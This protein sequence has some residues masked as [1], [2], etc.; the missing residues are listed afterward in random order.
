MKASLLL[1]NPLVLWAAV[2]LGA[3]GLL[4][5]GLRAGLE[6]AFL[7]FPS[8]RLSMTPGDVGLPF[9]EVRL[10]AED[11]VELHG[12]FV[13]GPG[14]ATLIWFHGNAGNIG[15]R[16]EPLKL[17]REGLG[18]SIFLFDY[19]GYGRS[20]GS[21]S[22]AGLYRDA[23]AALEYVRGRPDV[24]GQ[25]IVY[26]GQSLGAAVAAHLAT[27]HP[28][29]GLILE[30]A[31][32]SVPYMARQAYWFLPV[33][34]FLDSQYNTEEKLRAVR[35][36]VLVLH[37]EHDSIVP[38]EASRRIFEAAAGP[39]RYHVVRG[40]DHNDMFLTGGAEYYGAMRRLVEACGEN[41]G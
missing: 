38:V 13:P 28:P 11:G 16:V 14:P 33:W 39:K 27:Q 36:P 9:E 29:C 5:L 25:R 1:D 18:T 19:R 40:A 12:W 41:A 8:S 26:Y 31:F 10:A 6:G 24:D 7:Y 4:V 2:L 22:E 32:P 3:Y 30:A 37:G 34:P 23:A 35:A 17:L 15:H 20:A 21:P